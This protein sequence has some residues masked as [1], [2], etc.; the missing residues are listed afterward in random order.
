MRAI[1]YLLKI[2]YIASISLK[3]SASNCDIEIKKQCYCLIISYI[4]RLSD[5]TDFDNFQVISNNMD[6]TNFN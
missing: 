2:L 5:L 1:E 4:Y 6:L 3:S